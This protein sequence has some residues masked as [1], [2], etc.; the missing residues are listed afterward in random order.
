MSSESASD[1]DIGQSAKQKK[2][3]G[4]RLH[5]PENAEITRVEFHLFQMKHERTGSLPVVC[6]W[7]H[8]W[9]ETLCEWDAIRKWFREYQSKCNPFKWSFF[10]VRWVAPAFP[11]ARGKAWFDKHGS[12]VWAEDHI[13]P[14]YKI[15]IQFS[16]LFIFL[17]LI[18]SKHVLPGQDSI[19]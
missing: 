9:R 19:S 10:F 4:M 18:F 8:R 6:P 13:T 7:I 11:M 17:L 5:L 3:G 14:P 15:V 12:T 16:Y 1:E 2:Q